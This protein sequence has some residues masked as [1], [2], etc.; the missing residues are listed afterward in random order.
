MAFYYLQNWQRLNRN[1]ETSAREF[2]E[3]HDE[4]ILIY[5]IGAGTL[6]ITYLKVH[7]ES[8]PTQIQMLNKL[9]KSIGG[10][11]LDF[12]L[13]RIIDGKLKQMAEANPSIIRMR[14]SG[15]HP[16][17]GDIEHRNAMIGLKRDVRDGVKLE[18]SKWWHEGERDSEETIQV[19]VNEIAEGM[20]EGLEL[21]CD[22]IAESPEI[23]KFIQ[24]NTKT[25][26][27][28]FF[29]PLEYEQGN[30][31]IDTVILS[32]RTTLFPNMKEGVRGTI[33][34]WVQSAPWE[35]TLT[36]NELKSAVC[37]GALAYAVTWRR[38]QSIRI[39]DQNI[40]AKYGIFHRDETLRWRFTE[41]ISPTTS[42][43]RTH[44]T[45][46]RIF[47]EYEVSHTIDFTHTPQ[48]QLIQTYSP[49]PAED[50]SKGDYGLITFLKALN[51]DVF[52][53]NKLN[54]TVK[55]NWKNKLTLEIQGTAFEMDLNQSD[56][57][58]DISHRE[59]MWPL[60]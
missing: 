8:G 23:Q 34:K 59:G 16:E 5:D 19:Q 13:A 26:L 57:E 7:K 36:A 30:V 41:F 37:L 17:P 51:K 22:E 3:T 44:D 42:P 29:V 21:K 48:I 58:K 28:Q 54:V 56:F 27:E 9:G 49:H 46:G 12:I 47:H 53:S 38:H 14:F 2:L 50:F 31:P 1:R 10:N 35:V 25:V 40:W 24:N 55:L 52:S 45:G 43:I 11:N 20:E 32:G 18:Y 6:D 4:Y 60:L 39:I 33:E 15:L